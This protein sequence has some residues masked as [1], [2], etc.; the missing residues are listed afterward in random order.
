MKRERKY[1]AWNGK[2]MIYR[3][4]HDRNWY[5]DPT[6]GKCIKTAV[7]SDIH[8]EVMDFTGVLHRDREKYNKSIFD[9]NGMEMPRI[10]VYE[11]DIVEFKSD[12]SF[13]VNTK[14]GDRY[15]IEYFGAGFFMKPISWG[16]KKIDAP[17]YIGLLPPYQTSN[18]SNHYEVIG[19]IY[20][21]P[22]LL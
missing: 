11:G 15:I 18:M 14:L 20:Q 10:P 6:G 1:R 17:N 2:Y 19:N 3:G 8:L 13:Y 9:K 12:P 22:E 21:N 7:P 4:L 5:T 16:L